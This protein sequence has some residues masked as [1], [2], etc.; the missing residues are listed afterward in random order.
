MSRSNVSA[1]WTILRLT[2]LVAA[3]TSTL[4]DGLLPSA[5]EQRFR[6]EKEY[7]V[8]G[9]STADP[10]DRIASLQA[11]IDAGEASLEFDARDGFLHSVLA[12]LDID[13][14]SQVL[15]F[16]KTSLNTANISPRT[17]R[18][19]YFNDDTYVA[20]V[21]GAG[22]LEIASMD[23]ELGPLFYVL[24]EQPVTRVQFDRQTV[25]CLRC[26]D[27]LTLTG[28]GVPRFILG[29]GY[30]DTRGNLVSHE[31][32]ILTNQETPLRFR[33]GGWYVTGQHARQP[34]LG[35]II[36]KDPATLMDLENLRVYNLDSLEDLIE[37]ALY[38]RM[39]SDIVALMILEH[40]VHVQNL[41]T[42]VNYDTRMAI[43]ADRR[44]FDTDDRPSGPTITEETKS[45]IEAAAEPL[46]QALL[47]AG[48]PALESPIK[49]SS[50]FRM[51][52]E[53]RSQTDT[54]GRSFRQL[55]LR[56]RLFR[57][58]LS[59]LIDSPAFHGLPDIVR[60]RV[61]MRVVALLS[62]EQPDPLVSRLRPGERAAMLDMLFAVSPEATALAA[63]P[64]QTE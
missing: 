64:G 14:A 48:E 22:M 50:E 10:S 4:A 54:D 47:F 9:Y 30:I 23:P 61:L 37:A 40:Q 60:G 56:T 35:N 2:V 57:Y 27:S 51:S 49:G 8:I 46:V 63:G 13:P 31:G 43:E 16:S 7:P 1:G 5:E 24:E 3:S 34:H 62:T 28:G 53:R 58:P 29:S 36:V 11:R 33:W 42:R 55:D 25:Q 41:I 21:P 19:I 15:V 26:H 18:A 17:P 38:P 32:W 20:R 45:L 52:F 12:A 39:S 6:Y 44:R 59:Y